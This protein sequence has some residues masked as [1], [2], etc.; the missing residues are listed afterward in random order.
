MF[1]TEQAL[2][3]LAYGFVLLLLFLGYIA[4]RMR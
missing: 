1:T 4:G 3:L 2:T